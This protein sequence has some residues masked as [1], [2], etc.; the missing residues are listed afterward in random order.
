V[1][2]FIIQTNKQPTLATYLTT[3]I[4]SGAMAGQTKTLNDILQ[5]VEF[6]FSER[7]LRKDKF[8]Q[9]AISADKGKALGMTR[10]NNS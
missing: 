8:L 1:V 10:N 3:A 9:T 5:Q 2:E 4:A 6:Y 7:N